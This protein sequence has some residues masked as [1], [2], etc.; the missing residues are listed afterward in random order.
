V[1]A[2][3]LCHRC[4][5]QVHRL[6]RRAYELGLLVRGHADPAVVPVVLAAGDATAALLPT[7]DGRWEL[8]A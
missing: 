2:L 1:N 4:H 3:H 8:A 5:D 6:G 7:D